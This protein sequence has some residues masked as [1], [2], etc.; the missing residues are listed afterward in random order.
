MKIYKE[1]FGFSSLSHGGVSVFDGE[2]FTHYIKELSDD[3]VRVVFCDKKGNIWIGTHGNREGGLDRFAQMN[4]YHT[5]KTDDG[6]E[7]NNVRSIYEDKLG[8]YGWQAEIT[9]LSTFDGSH[10]K[11]FT[12]EKGRT[13]EKLSLS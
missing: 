13:F 6:F 2:N 10:F 7:N 1:I 8:N 5:I 11:V 12:D 3:F 4:L 9:E